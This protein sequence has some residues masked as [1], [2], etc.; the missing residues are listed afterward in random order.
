MKYKDIILLLLITFIIHS[1]NQSS[2]RVK[3]VYDGDTILIDSGE[4]IRYLGVDAP[5]ISHKGE[6]DGAPRINPWFPLH[7]PPSPKATAWSS[8]RREGR[9]H[10]EADG[11][12]IPPRINAGSSAKADEAWA[13]PER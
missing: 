2:K 13:V 4:K 11:N 8:A 7:D 9:H 5:E 3:F 10:A 1:F 12:S 6:K